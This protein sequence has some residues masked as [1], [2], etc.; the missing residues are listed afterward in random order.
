MD[1]YASCQF[2]LAGESRAPTIPVCLGWALPINKTQGQT[3]QRREL[4]SVHCACSHMLLATDIMHLIVLQLNN[5]GA[6]LHLPQPVFEHGQLNAASP[7]SEQLTDFKFYSSTRA[8]AC[9]QG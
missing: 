2:D 3:L 9:G 4:R 5:L 8:G 7:E 6:G 1:S